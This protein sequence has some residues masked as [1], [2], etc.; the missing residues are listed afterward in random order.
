[1][2]QPTS[3]ELN[4]GPDRPYRVAAGL[5]WLLVLVNVGCQ[6][7]TLAWPWLA[8]AVLLLAVLHP[9]LHGRARAP[10]KVQIF[11]DGRAILSG[12]EGTWKGQGWA[13]P[14]AAII[15]L[16][17]PV[18]KNAPRVAPVLVC[19][20]R[21]ATNDYRRLLVWNRYPPARAGSVVAGSGL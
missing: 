16:E 7:E 15:C 5:L 11:R 18:G 6:A 13:S 12:V 2:N 9:W 14:W 1:V 17:Q 4:T 3:I 10:G 20:S 19:A 21:N 8:A